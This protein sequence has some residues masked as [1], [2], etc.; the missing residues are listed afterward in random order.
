VLVVN[1]S[2]S[3]SGGAE[4]MTLR[5]A[6]FLRRRGHECK[7]FSS[8]ADTGGGPPV[9]DYL[10]KHNREGFYN[11]TLHNFSAVSTLDRAV[12]E[13]KPD[14]IHVRMFL[15]QLS[16]SI[17]PV[18]A[19]FPSVYHA[20]WY[21]IVCPTGLKMFPDGKRCDV[22]RGTVCVRKGCLNAPEWAFKM[23]QLKQVE[24]LKS[25][26]R[27]YLANSHA[28]GSELSEHGLGPVRVLWNAVPL[29]PER[30]KIDEHP[31]L[32][33]AGRLSQGKGVDILLAAFRKVLDSGITAT[34]QIAGNGPEEGR[35]KNLAASLQLGSTVY[36]HGHV[37]QA[38]LEERFAGAWA[39]VVPSVWPEPFGIVAAEAMMR[40]VPVVAARSGG[41]SEFISHEVTGFHVTPGCTEELTQALIRVLTEKESLHVMGHRARQF[42]IDHLSE[43]PFTDRLLQIYDE[44]LSLAVD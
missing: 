4:V 40:G 5:I 10:C 31:S 27:I 41:L 3:P 29:R 32:L 1:D 44:A 43:K 30:A 12:K 28:V 24:R 16:P 8:N 37:P 36:F 20:V 22:H 14:V 33:Y 6:D 35:L 34:L 26:F 13:F 25:A 7:V 39:Q 19:R 38:E 2:S 15:T 42:A 17:L 23:V 18:V 9:G 21:R 11:T